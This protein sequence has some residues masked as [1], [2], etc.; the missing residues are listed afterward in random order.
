MYTYI[1]IF[2]YRCCNQPLLLLPQTQICIHNAI[3]TNSNIYMTCCHTRR[4]KYSDRR[5]CGYVCVDARTCVR[6]RVCAKR[7]IP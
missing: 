1:H 2:V 4:Y 3:H 7:N 6:V 5:L